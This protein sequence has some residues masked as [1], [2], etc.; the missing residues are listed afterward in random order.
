MSPLFCWPTYIGNIDRNC[1][2][3]DFWAWLNSTGFNLTLGEPLPFFESFGQATGGFK[4]FICFRNDH[5]ITPSRKSLGDFF[6]LTKKHFKTNGPVFCETP[7]G[8]K[9]VET[10]RWK[11]TGDLVGLCFAFE[12]RGY[13]TWTAA[14]GLEN[15]YLEN[16][17]FALE[18]KPG[19]IRKITYKWWMFKG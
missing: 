7:D 8:I 2:G 13:V 16:S 3:V 12:D 17:H 11:K 14:F 10:N 19:F 9:K 5:S 6:C 15:I 1:A 4:T 18:K